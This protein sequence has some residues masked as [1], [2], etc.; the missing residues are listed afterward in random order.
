MKTVTRSKWQRQMS[1]S[2]EEGNL[3][4]SLPNS[5]QTKQI[6]NWEFSYLDT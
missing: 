6:L 5:R 3:K 1:E 4:K 2:G